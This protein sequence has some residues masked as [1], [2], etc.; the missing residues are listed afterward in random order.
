MTPEQRIARAILN[1]LSTYG[2]N[3]FEDSAPIYVRN[4]YRGERELIELKG[5]TMGDLKEFMAQVQL[6]NNSER[7]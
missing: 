7:K 4:T 6:R 5:L 3:T 2:A 1:T